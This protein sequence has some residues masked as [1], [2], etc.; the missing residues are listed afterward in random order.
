MSPYGVIDSQLQDLETNTGISIIN[1]EPEF[2]FLEGLC[3]SK[4]KPEYWNRLGSSKS[5]NVTQ[6]EESKVIIQ[7]LVEMSNYN[8]LIVFTDGSCLGNPGPCGSGSCIFVPNETEP[9]MLKRPVTNRGSILLGEL[10]AIL[11]ALEFA[12]SEH[13][14]RQIH[15]ITIFSDSQ[16]AV[17]ILTLGWAATSHKKAVEDI[18]LLISD[19]ERSGL[20]ISIQWTPGHADIRGNCIADDLAKEAA[21]EAKS[22]PEESQILTGA[23]FKKFARVSCCMKWQRSWDASDTGRHLYE[24]KPKVSLKSPT[25]MFMPFIEEKKVISQLRLGYTLNDY[26]HKIGLEESPNCTCGEIETV[27]HF[28]CD[29]EEYEEERQKLLTQ[30]FYLTGAQVISAE[31]FLSLK[32]EIF[33]EHRESLLMLLSEYI[34][35]TKRFLKK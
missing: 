5:R 29:C 35:S 7:S 20:E 18:K 22:F 15:G 10:I 26:R 30:M 8:N 25:Y 14:K 11:M 13:K 12:Q 27:V 21:E 23:D 24:Y 31:I 6:Q 32:E 2:S 4:S 34:T 19:L 33:K 3:P 1:V 9:V 17:G 16:S 28:I